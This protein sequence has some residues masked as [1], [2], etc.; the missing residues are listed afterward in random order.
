MNRYFLELALLSQKRTQII[1]FLNKSP[2][3]IAEI[4]EFLH[5]SSVA[6]LP[7]LKKLRE[8]FLVIK[9][10]NVYSLSPLGIAIAGRIQSMVDLIK[11]FGAQYDYW[12]NHAIECI[13]IPFLKRIGDLSD[14]TF[15]EPPGM[16]HLFEIHT[17]F[18]ENLE[19]SKKL[20]GV[21]YIF[22]LLIY[23]FSLVS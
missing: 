10:G 20:R 22:T 11:V 14:C 19:K 18:V 16:V 4:R 9:K 3:T 15:S 6:V 23:P 21:I 5:L 2:K 7:H 13:P 17:D 12:A 1:L 8:N